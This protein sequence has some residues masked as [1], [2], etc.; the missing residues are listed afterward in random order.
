MKKTWAAILLTMGL[1]SIARG[2]DVTPQERIDR[3]LQTSSVEEFLAQ[4]ADQI[5]LVVLMEV[6]PADSAEVHEALSAAFVVDSMRRNIVDQM[7]TASSP[8]VLDDLESW[9][10]EGPVARVAAIRDAHEPA[11]DLETYARSL[12]SKP[13]EPARI[14]AVA[15]HAQAQKAAGFYVMVQ[16]VT[17]EILGAVRGSLSGREA[18][19]VPFT[20]AEYVRALEAY[21]NVAVVSFLQQYEPVPVKLLEE[22]TERYASPAGQW[23]VDQYSL[24]VATALRMAGEKAV[25]RLER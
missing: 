21:F 25:S 1:P 22:S 18:E 5:E 12:Q 23:Y 3:I 14:R 2:Q 6:S 15:Q 20:D 4:A 19:F 16:E 17:R 9:L 11:V 13:P 8:A 24:A 10:F 7:A